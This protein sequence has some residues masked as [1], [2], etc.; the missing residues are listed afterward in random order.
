MSY[1]F[2]GNDCLPSIN[3]GYLVIRFNGAEVGMVSVPSPIFADRHRDSIN[4]NHD[5]FEDENGNTY[6]V[7][8]SSSNVGVDWTVNVSNSDLEQEIENLV[9]VEY[10]AN[11]Y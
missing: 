8:V 10:I 2:E 5:E 6:D 1:E 9:A 11:D 3:G 4:Q 7:F